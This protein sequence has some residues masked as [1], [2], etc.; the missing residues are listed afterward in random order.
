MNEKLTLICPHCQKEFTLDDVLSQRLRRHLLS[1]ADA[2]LKQKEAALVADYDQKLKQAQDDIKRRAE[3][4]ASLQ[5]KAVQ[6]ELAQRTKDLR[7]AQEQELSLRKQAAELGARRQGLE[8]E[9]ARKLDTERRRIQDETAKHL[10]EEYRLKQ[11]DNEQLISSLTTQIEGLRR[12]AQQG[13]QQAQGEALELDIEQQLKTAFLNDTIEPVA[14]GVKG[15]DIA[16]RVRNDRNQDCGIILWECKRVKAWSD[17]FSQKL[18]EDRNQSHADIAVIVTTSLP[19][20]INLLGFYEGVWVAAYPAAIALAGILRH[21]LIELYLN[22]QSVTGKRNKMDLMYGYL[23]GQE[24]RRRVESFVEGFIAI[25]TGLDSE[26]RAMQKIWSAREKQ[27]ERVISE[28]AAFY[29]DVQG[30]LGDS[31]SA[32][33]SL[34]LNAIPGQYIKSLALTSKK[35]RK[36]R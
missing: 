18:K 25:K 26:K 21:Q 29:G 33:K 27:L 12:S 1:D 9:V 34:E 36:P 32:I 10:N 15:A 13:S 4:S 23:S 6:D 7:Q 31:V 2:R 24:F 17:K 22:R 20:D 8:L 5:L 3:E 35:S 11:K 30:I 14:K 19:K 16:Q 28:I